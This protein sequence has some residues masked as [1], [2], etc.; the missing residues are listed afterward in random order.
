MPARIAPADPGRLFTESPLA[1]QE[2][3]G[4]DGCWERAMDHAVE[5]YLE[6]L[7]LALKDEDPALAQDVMW[8]VRER[9]RQELATAAWNAP[10][11]SRDAHVAKVLSELGSPEALLAQANQRERIVRESFRAPLPPGPDGVATHEMPWPSFWGVLWDARV[12]MAL[13]YLL[14]AL[15]AAVFAFAWICTGLSLSLSLLPLLIGFPLLVVFLMSLRALALGES[16]L[17]EVLLEVRMPRRP[18]ALPEGTGFFPRLKGL[19]LD[20]FTWSSLLYFLIHLPLSIGTFT[21]MAV[22]VTFSLAALSAP[23][24]W[25]TPLAPH[26][27]LNGVYQE[28]IPLSQMPGFQLA[29]AALVAVLL[30]VG[31][32]HGVLAL[33][34]LHG[35]LAKGL[36]VKRR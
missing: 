28:A 15:P 4:H 33:G 34:R 35:L 25:L 22:L 6:A 14:L 19:I 20:V 21:V 30:L 8:D 26:I 16:R 24:L 17:V 18:S 5:A 36:L 23:L 3:Y 10:E 31:T 13:L 9:I 12:Y 29:L 32:L 11:V 1:L 2:R 7:A 27:T